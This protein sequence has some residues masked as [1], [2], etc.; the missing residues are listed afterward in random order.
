MPITTTTNR[1]KGRPTGTTHKA[2]TDQDL[3]DRWC[4]QGQTVKE[5]A[6]ARGVSHQGVS[7]KVR[8][9][10]GRGWLPEAE[11]AQAIANREK[12]EAA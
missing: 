12:R 2:P 8:K 10:Q 11:R 9:Y 4:R 5:I 1:G 6:Q 3:I 7:E